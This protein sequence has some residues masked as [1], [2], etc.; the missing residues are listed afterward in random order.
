MRLTPEQALEAQLIDR[1]TYRGM[2]HAA[3]GHGGRG[4]KPPSPARGNARGRRD[5]D[6]EDA[7]HPQRILFDACQQRFPGWV[8][9]GRLCSEYKGAVPGRR[10]V[11]DVAF[12]EYRLAEEVD[13]WQ[14]HGK[15]KTDFQR[16]R[17]RDRALTRQGWRVLRYFYA[18]IV[19]DAA[20][21]ADEVAEVIALIESE[22]DRKSGLN[23]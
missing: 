19:E 13:G 4:R 10:F 21:L 3:R 6:V 5:Q 16:D 14:Y 17:L 23:R 22:R 15:R 2:V 9:S 7:A 8:E 12:P 11:L 18:E 20:G 1:E